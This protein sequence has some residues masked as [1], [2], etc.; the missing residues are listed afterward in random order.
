MS[1][2]RREMTGSAGCLFKVALRRVGVV[3][4]KLSPP[5]TAEQDEP[6]QQ[7]AEQR[8]FHAQ[9]SGAASSHHQRHL[10]EASEGRAFSSGAVQQHRVSR[11][12]ASSKNTQTHTKTAFYLLMMTVRAQHGP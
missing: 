4:F 10:A 3:C 9:P 6:G 12:G 7:G 11:C 8:E 1:A 5:S 2:R